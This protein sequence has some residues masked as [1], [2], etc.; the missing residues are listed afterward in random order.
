M[1]ELTL[2]DCKIG[3]TM[4][5]NLLDSIY[6]NN[7]KLKKFTLV[8]ANHS[9]RSFEKLVEYVETSSMLEYLDVSWSGV[10]PQMMIKLLKVIHENRNL[11]NLSLAYNILLEE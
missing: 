4:I 6:Y 7:A 2:I 10:R 11:K 1:E 8:K 3:A 9:D 5:E